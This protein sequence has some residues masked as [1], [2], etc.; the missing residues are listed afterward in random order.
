MSNESSETEILSRESTATTDRTKIR[1]DHIKFGNF[2]HRDPVELEPSSL[3]KLKESVIL[4]GL[5]VPIEFYRDD[6]GNVILLKGHRRVTVCR[7][8]AGEN[9]AGFTLDMEIDAIEVIKGTPED[10]LI[11]SISDNEVRATLDR[12][13]RIRVAKKLHDAG[14]S[15]KRAARAMGLSVKQYERDLLIAKYPW[16]FQHVIDGSIAPTQA[17]DLLNAAEKA[18]R[19]NELKE[20]L[21]AWI[22]GKKQKIREKERMLKASSLKDLSP[23]E[24]LVKKFLVNHLVDHWIELL[25]KAQRFDEDAHWNYS[26]SLDAESKK[27]S[28]PSVTLDLKKDSYEKLAKVG[29][30]LSLMAKLLQPF[31]TSRRDEERGEGA[32]QAPEAIYDLDYLRNLGVDDLADNLEE[33]TRLAIEPDGEEIAQE[34]PEE[35]QE[36]DLTEEV[37]LPSAPALEA[38]PPAP[39]TPPS[40]P[41]STPPAPAAPPLASEAPPPAAATPSAPAQ[42]KASPAAKKGTT[43]KEAPKK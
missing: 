37:Q 1:L 24:K 43:S 17:F 3:T 10:R 33:Q 31:I 30:K 2:C 34:E 27:L 23:A 32:Q 16:M 41:V 14:V 19:V 4:E 9:E 13:G 36:Q 29:S 28:I 11:R 8:L 12:M 7:I 18:K 42:K 26:A 25:G 5:Q 20:D 40:P 15:S 21:D 35:R 39:E 38:T 6:Q 22:A